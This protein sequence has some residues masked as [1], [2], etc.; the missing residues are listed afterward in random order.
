MNEMYVFTL[1][2]CPLTFEDLSVAHPVYMQRTF[3]H[4][5]ASFPS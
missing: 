4:I 2:L 1:A 3:A 5:L